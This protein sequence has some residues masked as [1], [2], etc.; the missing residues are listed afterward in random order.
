MM[1]QLTADGPAR[2]VAMALAVVLAAA[3]STPAA[4]EDAFRV[5]G[6]RTERV[7]LYD[8]GADKKKTGQ[9]LTKGAFAGPLA[10][11][12]EPSSSL[13]VKVQVNGQLYC[14]KAYQVATD[15]PVSVSA[16]CSSQSSGRA[17]TTGAKRGLG[18]GCFED[19]PTGRPAGSSDG[20]ERPPSSPGGTPGV[21]APRPSD[22]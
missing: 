16:E 7:D 5:T 13:Y 1:F 18:E 9:V 2:S 8:C 4:Q 19:G 22:P 17:P 21:K 11:T 15:K 12:R 6:L 14:V 3:P 20:R 10:A